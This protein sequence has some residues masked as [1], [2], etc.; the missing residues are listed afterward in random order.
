MI[1]GEFLMFQLELKLDR[2]VNVLVGAPV[3]S[4]IQ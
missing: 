3:I 2:M 4:F 1:V